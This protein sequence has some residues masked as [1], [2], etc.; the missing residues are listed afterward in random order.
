MTK[1]MNELINEVLKGKMLQTEAELNVLQAQV[2]PHFLYNNLDTAYWMNRLEK[3]EKTGKVV[4][5]IADL[6]R[7]TV[8][9]GHRLI[10]V[11]TEIRYM[12]DYIVIQELRVSDLIQFHV[13]IQDGVKK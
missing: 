8:N 6:Y 12:E 10:P 7:L 1:R 11:E 4:L 3:A 5:A 9:F 13:E 2:D